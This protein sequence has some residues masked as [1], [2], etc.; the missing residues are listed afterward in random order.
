[1]ADF[2][3]T[4][5]TELIQQIFSWIP[6]NQNIAFQRI[7]KRIHSC[8]SSA[9][10]ALMNLETLLHSGLSTT[11]PR[12]KGITRKYPLE[13]LARD[14]HEFDRSF[15][16]WPAAYQTALVELRYKHLVDLFWP[17]LRIEG[18]IPAAIGG[19]KELMNLSMRDNRIVGSIPIEIGMLQKL[20][21]LEFPRNALTGPIPKEIGDMV[22]L[23]YISLNQNSLSGPLPSEIGNLSN[24]ITLYLGGNKLSGPIPESLGNCTRLERL[25]LNTNQFSGLLPKTLENLTNLTELLLQ[26]NQLTGPILEEFTRFRD[27]EMLDLTRN[28]FIGKIPRG[29]QALGN[30]RG[31]NLRTFYVA[32][33]NAGLEWTEHEADG[34]VLAIRKCDLIAADWSARNGARR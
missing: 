9:H 17:T 11:Q 24:L 13:I 26:S 14:L 20:T 33:G 21:V 10:F 3:T 18:K 32:D 1:M 27:L 5:P 16:V 30:V 34:F 29:F 31:G 25:H 6:P 23:Q 22:N 8:L 15:F 4:T 19:M 28:G 12:N 2:P 7:S